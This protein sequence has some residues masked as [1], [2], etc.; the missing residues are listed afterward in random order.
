MNEIK[1]AT[2]REFLESRIH[3][4]FQDYSSIKTAIVEVANGIEKHDGSSTFGG[5]VHLATSITEASAIGNLHE[6]DFTIRDMQLMNYGI[7]ASHVSEYFAR[8]GLKP[9][10]SAIG[11]RALDKNHAF[12]VTLTFNSAE[13]QCHVTVLDMLKTF[14]WYSRKGMSKN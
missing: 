5:L 12:Y 4:T 3:A 2:L 1:Y 14:V 9:E 7:L 10:S 11:I 6:E 8:L 13:Q